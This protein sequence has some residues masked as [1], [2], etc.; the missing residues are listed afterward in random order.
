M[1]SNSII[2]APLA[3]K[4]PHQL[5]K[6]SDIRIDNYFWMKDR[7]H[8]E[9]IDYLKAENVYCDESMA[10]TKSFQKDLFEEMKAR[11]KEDDSSVPYKYNGY[12]Y[13]TKFEKGKDY[14]IYLRKKDSLDNPE[15]LLF[16][17]NAMAEG[18]RYFKLAGISI[19]PDN[20][21]PGPISTIIFSSFFSNSKIL[22]VQRTLLDI[23]NLRLLIIFFEVAF[24]DA[25]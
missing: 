4:N 24:T 21:L 14:P 12:W 2:K 11:I 3:K 9:V 22:S 5:E 7:E 10:H 16:D 1:A 25:T 17:C 13:I 20:T 6:H 15:E 18:E 23:C 19:S 8:P